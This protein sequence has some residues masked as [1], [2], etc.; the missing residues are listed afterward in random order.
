MKVYVDTCVYVELFE[1][2]TR[3]MLAFDFFAKGWN[4][5]FELVVSD[6]VRS[7]L[8]RKK[9]DTEYP[10][11]FERFKSKNK[12]HFVEH[13][14]EDLE[15]ARSKSEH[16]QDYLHYII[17]KK[18]GCDKIV[19]IDREFISSLSPIFDITYPENI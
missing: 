18:A 12:F 2:D 17:A 11:L 3:S 4:C 14:K 10:L 19:T 5:A 13:T 7:E 15:L 1:G 8:K 16:W 9:L 6:W